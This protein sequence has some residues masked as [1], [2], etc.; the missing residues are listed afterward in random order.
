MTTQNFVIRDET[1]ADAATIPQVTVAA[2]ETMEI[3]NHTEQFIIEALRSA[4]A[5]ALDGVDNIVYSEEK[6]GIKM[7]TRGR[8][9]GIGFVVGI[10]VGAVIGAVTGDLQ[11]WVAAGTVLGLLIGTVLSRRTVESKTDPQSDYSP[12]DTL[13]E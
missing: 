8:T 6:G 9:I 1:K 4:R 11:T 2:F 5:L 3:S 7:E 13:E 10:T 12:S